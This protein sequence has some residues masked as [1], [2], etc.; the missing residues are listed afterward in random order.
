MKRVCR[1]PLTRRLITRSHF[2]Q[3]GKNFDAPPAV[4]NMLVI[5]SLPAGSFGAGRFHR[6]G[7]RWK[8]LGGAH[9]IIAAGDNAAFRLRH[10]R[11]WADEISA[12][13]MPGRGTTIIRDSKKG[14][15]GQVATI[16]D[17][18]ELRPA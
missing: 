6:R 12:D 13:L 10:C 2:Q 9:T 8:Q 1:F 7:K 17:G 5:D 11:S 4:C 14:K 16:M 18:V 3:A 15:Y